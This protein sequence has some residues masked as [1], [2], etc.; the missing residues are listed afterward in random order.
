MNKELKRVIEIVEDKKVDVEVILDVVYM[1]TFADYFVIAIA[2]NDRQI[3]AIMNTF[4]EDFTT[5]EKANITI[6]GDAKDGWVAIQYHDV[7]LHLFLPAMHAL[8]RLD[9]LYVDADRIKF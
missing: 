7:C 8:Y 1:S 5:A 6:E 4:K 2:Q 9:E 3:A